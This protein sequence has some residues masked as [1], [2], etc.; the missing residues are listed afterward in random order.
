M[1]PFDPMLESHDYT[2]TVQRYRTKGMK[3]KRYTILMSEVEWWRRAY[4][5]SVEGKDNDLA[6]AA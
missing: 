5:E 3:R 1:S 2:D 6:V 4:Q